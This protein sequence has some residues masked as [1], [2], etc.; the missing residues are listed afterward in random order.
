MARV[1]THEATLESIRAPIAS[2]FDRFQSL[3]DDAFLCDVLLVG[4]VGAHLHRAFGKRFRPTLVLLSAKAFGSV[5]DE[6]L[7]G[8]VV[9][10]LI[11]TATLIHDDSVDKSLVRRSLPTVNSAWSNDVAILMG[12]YLYSKAFSIMVREKMY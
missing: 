2:S 1:E 5:S 4:A 8:A 7:R 11:H 12:D 10:E 6:V 9:V 3:W